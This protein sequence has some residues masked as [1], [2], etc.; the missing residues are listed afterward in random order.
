VS[1]IETDPRDDAAL[2]DA[3]RQGD[4]RALD[5][6]VARYYLLLV[7]FVSRYV[8]SVDASEDVVQELFIRLWRRRDVLHVRGTVRTYLFS[9]ARNAARDAIDSGTAR[10]RAEAR[11]V[12]AA[13][14]SIGISLPDRDVEDA[15]FLAMVASV[16]EQLP[17]RCRDVYLLARDQGLSYG[18]IAGVLGIAPSTVRTQMGRALAFLERRIGP[19]LALVLVV[20]S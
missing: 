14:E 2:V 13:D 20:R 10:A 5:T 4:E 6:L 3:M 9:A 7:A 18:E 17:E 11:A 1:P 12:D 8:A 19:L 16:T 15:D